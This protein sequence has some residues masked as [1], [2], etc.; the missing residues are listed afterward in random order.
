MAESL[1]QASPICSFRLTPT[2]AFLLQHRGRRDPLRPHLPTSGQAQAA[3][4]HDGQDR[5]RHQHAHVQRP[6]ASGQGQHELQHITGPRVPLS[7]G[8]VGTTG[9]R[10]GWRR[11]KE[12]GRN[13]PIFTPGLGAGTAAC[14]LGQEPSALT[15]RETGRPPGQLLELHLLLFLLWVSKAANRDSQGQRKHTPLSG[16][17]HLRLHLPPQSERFLLRP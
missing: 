17:A 6:P 3:A 8:R 5:R 2:A 13:I 11:A 10:A 14:L 4:P 9:R 15:A 1:G 16:H 7:T 12:A